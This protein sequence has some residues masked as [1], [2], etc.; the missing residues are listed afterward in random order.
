MILGEK[1][2][3]NINRVLEKYLLEIQFPLDFEGLEYAN[4]TVKVNLIGTKMYVLNGNPTSHLIYSLSIESTNNNMVNLMYPNGETINPTYPYVYRLSNKVDN[5]L[6]K[7]LQFFGIK[8]PVMCV[9][10]INNSTNKINEEL[11]VEEKY[12]S[13]TKKLVKDI[14]LTLKHQREGEF[15][16]PED[17]S[18]EMVY[19]FPQFNSEFTINLNLSTS[20][21]VKDVDV[22]GEYYK[23]EDTID[24]NITTNPNIDRQLLEKLYHELNDVVR[25]EIQHIIQ[26]E[27]GY[28][29]PKREPKKP[30]K[31]Y[32]Q[33]HELEAQIAGFK[34][35]AKK[36]KKPFETV[37]RDWFRN[38]SSKHNM[39]PNDVEKV[40]NLILNF[41]N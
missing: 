11:I 33:K 28:N 3:D 38:N 4:V 5:V 31:Y 17:I 12:D 19:T 37:V 24:I 14:L 9:K 35:R 21:D 40:I 39:T 2:K 8:M 34:R 22:D 29:F 6:I 18:D 32:T 23:G 41:S 15:V 13:V 1:L 20:E 25:H 36:E 7:F 27:S 10:A 30:L 16:L 26:Y